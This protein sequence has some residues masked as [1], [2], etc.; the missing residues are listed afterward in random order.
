MSMPSPKPG[1]G[2]QTPP[3]LFPP[4]LGLFGL[5]LAW[6]RAGELFGFG[7]ALSDMILGAVTGLFAYAFAAYLAKVFRRPGALADDLRTLPGRAGLAAMSLSLALTSAALSTLVPG[8]ALLLLWAA[9]AWHVGLASSVIVTLVRGPAEQ[10]A[11]TPVWHL[12]FVGFIVTAMAATMQGQA[13]LA[14]ILFAGTVPVALFIWGASLW[15]ALRRG[16]P[17]PPLRPV[18]AIH[19]APAALFGSVALG[20]GMTGL[21]QGSAGLALA[22]LAVMLW[23]ARWMTEAGFSPFWGAFTFP[24][25]ATAGLVTGV[26]QATGSQLMA[27]LGALLLVLATGLVGFVAYR[28][29]KLWPSGQLATRTAAARA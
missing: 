7:P 11:V 25:A 28:V 2:A 10:R 21:A 20:L 8:L 9:L 13:G 24:A 5:G 29:L 18:M 14:T 15:Q 23:R 16:L 3:A 1:F 19:L 4:V 27:A 6:R 26:A 17:P 22:I 12:N